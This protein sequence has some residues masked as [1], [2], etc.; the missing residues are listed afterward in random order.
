MNKQKQDV[1]QKAIRNLILMN[2]A[3]REMILQLQ[4]YLVEEENK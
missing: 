1:S 4:G 2:S 3:M